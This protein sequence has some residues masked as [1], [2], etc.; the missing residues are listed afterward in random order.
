MLL[1]HVSDTHLGAT[2]HGLLFRHIDVLESFV[3]T[4]DIALREHVDVY[5]H[6]GDFFDRSTPPPDAY[7]IAY[8][9]LK[10]LKEHNI[11]VYIIAGQ[12]DMPRKYG[13]SPLE[14]LQVF[15]VVDG[16]AISEVCRW[17]L[18][19]EDKDYTI[20]GI[21]Y[22][23]R[24][25]LNIARIEVQKISNS[26]PILAA[27]LLLKELGIPNYDAS[28]YDIP[29]D[30]R[31]VA[32]GDYHG[33]RVFRL[34]NGV[35]VV[36][37]GATEVF[38]R[39]EWCDEGKRV[40]LVDLS[41]H[42]PQLHSI[43]LESVRPWIIGEYSNIVEALRDIEERARR[44]LTTSRKKPIVT[45]KIKSHSVSVPQ[46][47]RELEKLVER[48]LIEYFFTPEIVETTSKNNVYTDTEIQ[49][50]TIDIH[51]ILIGILK[52]EAIAKAVYELIQ[53]P[54]EIK[55]KK[56]LE[57]ILENL[58]LKKQQES[59][60]RITQT[61]KDVSHRNEQLKKNRRRSLIDFMVG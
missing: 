7:M 8:R 34:S 54:S 30:Y 43:K 41:S 35:P 11:K 55:A 56:V 27:H 61:E 6:T 44:I 25:Q 24:R 12:H 42:E 47:Q 14:T 3:E 53:D 2:P 19:I 23:K 51:R 16:I 59:T 22:S 52:N 31:Y 20:V 37:P 26:I 33:F 13:V 40:V 21:P 10:R 58:V 18:R 38:K 49:F 57:A 45:M 39:D 9:H 50:E 1:L 46:L 28:L 60:P 36:Y 15:G 17:S 48:G 29:M 5:L 32:L 4:I